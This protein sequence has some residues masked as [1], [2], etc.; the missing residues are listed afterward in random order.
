MKTIIL[1]IFCALLI[2]GCSLSISGGLSTE[3]YY[4]DI[5]TAKGGGFGDPA[6]S[7]HEVTRPST[8]HVRN[9]DGNNG[10]KVDAALRKFFNTK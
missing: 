5:R 10:N 7:R 9:N 6:K 2:Q 3:A 8:S 4:P 1:T